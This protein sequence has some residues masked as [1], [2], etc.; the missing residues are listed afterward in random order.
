MTKNKALFDID[1]SI[2]YLEIFEKS[3][4]KLYE[5]HFSLDN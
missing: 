1:T 4:V 5:K 2:F 3:V